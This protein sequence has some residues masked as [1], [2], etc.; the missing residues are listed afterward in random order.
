MFWRKS[1]NGQAKN[2]HKK[3]QHVYSNCYE[4]RS[5]AINKGKTIEQKILQFYPNKSGAIEQKS[6]RFG[7]ALLTAH[8]NHTKIRKPTEYLNWLF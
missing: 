8:K 2:L 3:D 7:T 4:I 1:Q 6:L 5:R